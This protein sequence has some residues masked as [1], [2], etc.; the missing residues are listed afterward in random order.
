[1]ANEWTRLI[2][3]LEEQQ[4]ED[5]TVQMVEKTVRR[6]K[7]TEEQRRLQHLKNSETELLRKVSDLELR[8]ETLALVL[9]R[10]GVDPAEVPE[11]RWDQVQQVTEPRESQAAAAVAQAKEEWKQAKR[12]K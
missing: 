11:L 2:K 4:L 12:K 7:Q 6:K 10:N 1:M 8:L 9:K 5:G 3:V